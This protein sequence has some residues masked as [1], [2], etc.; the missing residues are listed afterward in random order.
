MAMD[1]WRRG[2]EVAFITMKSRPLSTQRKDP[3][4]QA[5]E[6]LERMLPRRPARALHWLHH[7]GS[8]YVRIPL[9]VLCIIGGLFWFLPVLG[10][11]L[12]PIGLLLIA[13]D[14][15]FLHRPIGRMTLRLLD[16]VDALV[17]RWKAW[18]I[19][20]TPQH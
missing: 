10:L 8:R 11:E 17:R 14:I 2:D 19:R 4:N 15:P 6:R 13:Q 7:P 3:L 12:L 1:V 9:G 18:R 5:F 16:A 20:R